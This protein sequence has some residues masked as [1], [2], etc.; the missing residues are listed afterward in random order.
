[1]TRTRPQVDTPSKNPVV[2]EIEVIDPA[3][4]LFGRRFAIASVIRHGREPSNVLVRYREN[5]LLRIPLAA[6]TLSTAFAIKTCTKLSLAA[7]DELVELANACEALCQEDRE[8]SGGKCR[9]LSGAKSLKTS[10]QSW[11][12]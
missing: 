4:A 10:R 2:E 7:V 8:T 5:I 9:K 3:H 12:K 11:R 1:M 6:T